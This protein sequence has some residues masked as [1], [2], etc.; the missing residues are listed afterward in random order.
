MD[1]YALYERFSELQEFSCILCDTKNDT[2][3]L[4]M[5]RFDGTDFLYTAVDDIT[6]LKALAAP[7]GG[8]PELIVVPNDNEEWKDAAMERKNLNDRS[9]VV[10]M[11]GFNFLFNVERY[12]PAMPTEFQKKWI[13]EADELYL[14]NMIHGISYMNAKVLTDADCERLQS[15]PHPVLAY[16]DAKVGTTTIYASLQHAGIPT[17]TLHSI[18]GD[19]IVQTIKDFGEPIKVISGVR[20][21]IAKDL[22]HT[23]MF[24]ASAKYRPLK[25]GLAQ[26]IEERYS[27]NWN[28]LKYYFEYKPNPYGPVFGWFDSELKDNFGLD[29]FQE[30][31]DRERGFSIYRNDYVEA[32]VYKLER[33]NDLEGELKSF[34]GRENFVITNA[35]EASEKDIKYLYA[36]ARERLRPSDNYIDFYYLDNE[37]MDFFYTPEEKAAFEK[38]WRRLSD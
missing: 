20:D 3:R 16:G 33:L 27:F 37:R 25:G 34:L 38:K 15:M 14:E 5:D 19:K 10:S 30:S 11:G 31:F 17:L 13:K 2:T 1:D 18:R 32:F 8:R 12:D 4:W 28:I 6:G 7:T 9:L 24:L 36:G 35:N 29:I 23:F 26:C 22:S 21:P